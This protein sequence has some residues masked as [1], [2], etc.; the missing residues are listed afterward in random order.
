MFNEMTLTFLLVCSIAY[1][2]GSIP[3]GI[4][5]AKY[6][7]LGNLREIGSGNI[8]ATN[9][10]RTGNKKA[11]L[12]TLL[13]DGLKGFFAV[14]IIC[15]LIP[16][17][18]EYAV[19]AGVAAMIGHVFPVWLKFKGGKGVAT[20]LGSQFGISPFGGGVVAC[21]IWLIGGKMSKISSVGALAAA[22]FTAPI[23]YFIWHDLYGA[24]F[25]LIGGFILL[26]THREN[27]MRLCKGE[28]G[29]IKF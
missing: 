24:I 22:I 27:I 4:L 3:F 14:K 5:A 12:F 13:A 8:G 18:P 28:E 26:I 7:N 2:I 16:G 10:L 17:K 6:F 15:L 19:I 21:L 20:F 9:V 25:S 1:C 23:Q 29:K 11:A